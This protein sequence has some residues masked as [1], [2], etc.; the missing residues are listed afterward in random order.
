MRFKRALHRVKVGIAHFDYNFAFTYCLPILW[1]F[2]GFLGI[3]LTP[4]HVNTENKFNSSL[5]QSNYTQIGI[6]NQS[7]S[8][9]PI[10]LSILGTLL[11]LLI[12]ANK[13]L[14]KYDV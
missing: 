3:I 10:W 4:F 14:E 1:F 13:G 6:Y 12:I 9:V 11:G 8:H 5:N 7:I 2:V